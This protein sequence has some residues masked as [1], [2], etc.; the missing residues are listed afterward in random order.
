MKVLVGGKWQGG[1][2]DYA[3][4]PHEARLEVLAMRNLERVD[5]LFFV[6]SASWRLLL[7]YL[8]EVG[9]R[10]VL[11]KVASRSRERHRNEKFLSCGV[12]RV[13]ESTAD[14]EPSPGRTVGFVAPTHPACVERLVLPIELLRTDIDASWVGFEQGVILHKAVDT[15]GPPRYLLSGWS[16][17][18]G[19]ALEGS[20][21]EA[22]AT[23]LLESLAPP[24]RWNGERLSTSSGAEDHEPA[25]EQT[26]P[27]LARTI[28]RSAILFGYGNYA[29]TTVLPNV[30]PALRVTAVHEL[31]PTQIP[32]LRRPTRR[33]DTSP[34]P[35]PNEHFDA[36]LIAGY[37][38]THAP[39]AI[40]ALHRG[41]VAIVEKPIATNDTQLA[42][43]IEAL[44]ASNGRLF[45][46]FQRRYSL[47]TAWAREDLQIDAASAVDYHCLV[48]EVPLPDRHWYRWPSS[49]S[50]LLSNGCHWVDHFLFLNGFAEVT[51]HEVFAR[52]DRTV[53]CALEL[54][55]GASFSMSLTD[56]GS[57]RVGVRDVV[58]LRA[59]DRT[60]TLIDN[61]LYS[62]EGADRI[63][64][65]R[66][67]N[68]VASYGR[69]YAEIAQ[70]VASGA[71]G[72]TVASVRSS[73]GAVLALERR[74]LECRGEH[75]PNDSAILR[76]SLP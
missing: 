7:N 27:R 76:R 74:L 73:A 67:A 18:S 26:V 8:R 71:E 63:L 14:G 36:F 43:L 29:K 49:G 68:K 21:L 2:L 3:K 59:G 62:A 5:D 64:R 13:L 53:V 28:P 24:D 1:F 51:S 65:R 40:E 45:A 20:A 57:P 50:R 60:A 6:R 25:C 44:E 37:H 10:T 4:G 47:L 56:A 23:R 31:D 55:N 22:E 19:I 35:R 70:R 34:I 17:H 33:W 52:P 61:S 48:Y 72:D 42:D 69:M 11:R 58:Q 41:A 32:K 66:K 9:P 46:C 15:S 30:E 75:P 38:S 54:A 12:A 39:L 16:P